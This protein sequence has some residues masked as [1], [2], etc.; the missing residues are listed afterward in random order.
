[1]TKTINLFD[2]RG[3]SLDLIEE[4]IGKLRSRASMHSDMATRHQ[5]EMTLADVEHAL[6]KAL[7]I[8]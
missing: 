5:A 4:A 6:N 3:F 1:M 2:T 7:S 8:T